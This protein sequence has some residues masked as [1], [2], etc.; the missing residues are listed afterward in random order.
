MIPRLKGSVFYFR[1]FL[2]LLSSLFGLYGYITGMAFILMHIFSLNSF[3]TD[4]TVSLRRADFQSFKDIFFRAPWSK[5]K[6]RPAFN[7]NKV[8]MEIKNNEKNS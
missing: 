8:R 1:I 5:M 4:Y 6:L 3:G 2:V 7:R